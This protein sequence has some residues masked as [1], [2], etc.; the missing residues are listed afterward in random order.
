MRDRRYDEFLVFLNK[1]FEVL[2]KGE[3][4]VRYCVLGIWELFSNLV[5]G[6][7]GI[8]L[9]FRGRFVLELLFL[10]SWRGKRLRIEKERVISRFFLMIS[11]ILKVESC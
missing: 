11:R 8:S 3:S 10:E 7:G 9:G 2:V 6:G 4:L 5:V 1:V